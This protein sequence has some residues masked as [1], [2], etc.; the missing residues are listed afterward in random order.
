M[1]WLK[2]DDGWADRPELLRLSRGHRL[3]WLEGMTYCARHLTDGRIV[4]GALRRLSDEPD[5][6]VAAA[7]LVVAGLWLED[8]DG[9]EVVGYLVPSHQGGHGQS[10][11]AEVEDRREVDAARQRTKRDRERRH[12]LGD[13]TACDRCSAVRADVRRDSTRESDRPIHSSPKERSEESSH[14]SR[15]SG[16]GA[17]TG[18][19]PEPTPAR[20]THESPRASHEHY[21]RKAKELRGEVAAE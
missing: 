11:R 19:S 14:S 15:P 1:T 2:L 20:P 9:F 18:S 4:R 12:S 10:S 8:E 16:A 21:L 3:L 5:V 17:P 7:A 13:H 6:E